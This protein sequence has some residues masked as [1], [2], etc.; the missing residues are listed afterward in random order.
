MEKIRLG[1]ACEILNGFAFKSENYVDSGIRVIRIAN[2][3]KGYIEDNT[4]AFYPLG[5]V[6]LDKYMLEEGD[7]LISLTGNVGRVAILEKEFLPAALN[8]RVAC[9]RLKTS[10]LTKGYLFHIL[11]GNLFEQQCIQSSKGVAQKN[12]STEWL[13][14]Y[15]IPLYSK[16]KQ[17]IITKILDK[18]YNVISCRQQEIQ[19]F[20]DLIKARFVE[21]FGDIKINEYGWKKCTFKDV[22]TKITDGEHG[23]VPRV[24]EGEGYLYFMARNITKEGEIDLS[25]TSFVPPEIHEKIYKRCNPEKDDLLLVC[26]GA[27]IGKCTLVSEIMGEFSMARSVALIKPNKEMVTSNFLINLLRSEAIENDIDHCSHAAA[28]AGLYTNMINSLEAFVPPMDLQI[29]FD[30]FCKQVDKSKLKE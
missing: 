14:N 9:L 21:M 13:K 24:D 2:V 18:T 11:N 19:K 10:R 26:V 5:S 8:Q 16:E 29:E 27:T 25:E 15:E 30:T 23:T 4:P 22:S 20:D 28:Q 1:D 7:L 17:D 3:Q 12:M 6:G